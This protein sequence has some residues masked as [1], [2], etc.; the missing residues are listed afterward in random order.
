M[1]ITNNVS[2]QYGGRKLFEEV[3]IKFTPGNCYGLIGANG[4]GKSTFL[5]ILAGEIE[6]TTGSIFVTPGQRVSYLKQDHYL[7]DEIE[8]LR[9]VIMGN[10]QLLEVMEEKDALY[11]KEDFSDE[12]GIRAAE[13]EGIFAE[14]NGYEAEP[15]AA[16]L[17]DGLGIKTE[18]HQLKLKDLTGAEK[19]K[20][21][22][23]KALFGKPDILLLDE[24]TNHLD[25]KAIHWLENFLLDFPNTVVVVSHD[26]H[27]LNKVCTHTADIDFG[28]IQIYS[29]NYDFW[30]QS[31][32]LALTLKS[33]Q[34]K[35]VEE[36]I[37]ELKEFIARFSAN[38]S[39]SSQATSRKKMLD[40]IQL[41]DIKP[42]NRKYPYIFFKPKK[43][44]GKEILQVEKLTKTIDG[45]VL[46]KNLSFTLKKND[47]VILLGSDLATSTLLSILAGETEPDTGKITW[48]VTTQRSYFPNDN[49]K[50]FID[51]KLNLVD[52][53]RDF[54]EDKDE[55]F[56]RGFL[57]R[58][59]FSG[60]E[61]QKKTNVLSGGERV[62]M[63]LSKMMLEAGNVLLLDRPTDHLDLESITSLNE[64]LSKVDTNLM[65][66]CHDHQFIQT[67]ANRIIDIKAD[68]SY[69]DV[70]KSYDDYLGLD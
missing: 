67:V 27:F 42:S 30:Y 41:E 21:L 8:V 48:G 12:D 45:K 69:E 32:Q 34:N 70:E 47:K 38:A 4:A 55:S 39:K 68:G 62:R 19:V 29:G 57:G 3:D 16:V 10:K 23:A 61:S 44:L 2:L 15:D 59:L 1:I 54:S 9:V 51:G 65:F 13:L 17:L 18:Q 31:S 25:I 46:F 56:V 64:S 43:E 24:P 11:M 22:L 52:W 28:K 50:Y 40:K 7:Y 6:P 35:K 5:K 37:K 33:N 58:M 66:T 49:T 20:V 60:E 63:M 36:K 53:L 14:M 26:R